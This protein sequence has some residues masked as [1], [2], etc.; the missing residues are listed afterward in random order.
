MA[1]KA[2]PNLTR[3]IR[4]SKMGADKI[5]TPRLNLW[6][7]QNPNW[8]V[9]PAIA[10]LIRDLMMRKQRERSG[11]FS[12][13]SAGDCP[14]RQIYDYM[15]LASGNNGAQLQNLFNDGT[16]RHL[17][18]QAMLLQAGILNEVEIMLDWPSM[19]SKGSMDGQ[20]VVPDDHP[21]YR[22]RGMEFGFELKGMNTFAY[23]SYSLKIDPKEQHHQQTDRYFLS[24]GHD[25]FVVI[26]ED[27]NTQEWTEWVYEPDKARMEVQQRELDMLNTYADTRTIPPMLPECVKQN[28]TGE[29]F[30]CKFGGAHGV[31]ANRNKW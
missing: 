25:L 21:N 2:S 20:G 10:D 12:S 8:S 5:I 19:K 24:G 22:W 29:W 4:G 3:V 11:S 31:C 9:E 6:L 16:W 14:R 15:G 30:K 28:K 1:T 17:R 13:S 27:K 7:M 26:Y 23:Q 18:W